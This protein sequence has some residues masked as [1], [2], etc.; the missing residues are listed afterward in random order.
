MFLFCFFWWAEH[1][2]CRCIHIIHHPVLCRSRVARKEPVWGG[3]G[4]R[5]EKGGWT[6]SCNETDR[7]LFAHRPQREW[8]SLDFYLSLGNSVEGPDVSIL[9]ASVC[10]CVC[11]CGRAKCSDKALPS[12]CGSIWRNYRL[13]YSVQVAQSVNRPLHNNELPSHKIIQAGVYSDEW[14]L[15]HAAAPKHDPCYSAE[16]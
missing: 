7:K 16:V 6:Q 11:V 1:I 15:L 4:S 14:L 10:V 5:K 2:Y 9:L 12:I 8:C 3:W 13:L